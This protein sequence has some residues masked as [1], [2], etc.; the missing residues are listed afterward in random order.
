MFDGKY[1]QSAQAQLPP[2]KLIYNHRIVKI[3][4]F[5][6]EPDIFMHNHV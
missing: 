4:H 6:I 5:F 1:F 2:Y 3:N